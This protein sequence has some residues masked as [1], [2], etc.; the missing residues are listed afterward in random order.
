[1]KPKP[2]YSQCRLT[3]TEGSA[4][5]ETVSWLPTRVKSD[6][7]MI[8]L[9][10]GSVVDLKDQ[11]GNWTRGWCVEAMGTKTEEE[12]PDWRKSVR[13]HRKNTGDSIRR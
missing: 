2:H 10:V 12:A 7:G 1:M 4:R 5:I 9:K 3:R 11:E 6:K 8:S 13:G